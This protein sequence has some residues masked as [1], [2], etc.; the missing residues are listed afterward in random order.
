MA[1]TIKKIPCPNG[2]VTV[3][4]DGVFF[5]DVPVASGG[6]ASINVPSLISDASWFEIVVKTDNAGS[7]ASN[8]I[9]L[10]FVNNTSVQIDRGDGTFQY[11]LFTGSGDNFLTLIYAVAGT[12]TI[13]IYGKIT[14]LNFSSSNDSNKLLAIN[15]WGFTDWGGNSSSS[16]QQDSY[17]G[18]ENM[19]LN[20]TDVPNLSNVTNM[21][22]FFRASSINSNLAHWVLGS[23]L[24]TIDG[25]FRNSD[26]STANYT[27]TIVGWALK[28]GAPVNVNAGGQGGMTFDT[29]RPVNIPAFP[30][31]TTAGQAR[32]FI[33]TP[34]ASGG[35]G[36]TISGDTVI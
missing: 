26:M 1:I 33:T 11:Y 31:I 29:S 36:W 6:T 5:A 15:N 16:S 20:A 27:D 13:K 23:L 25:I 22:N 7:S 30:S 28:I 17:R 3:N 34:V 32:T 18:T 8:Q 12:Y 4:R 19:V 21:A 24:T 9:T 35:L 14:R 10:P 2:T